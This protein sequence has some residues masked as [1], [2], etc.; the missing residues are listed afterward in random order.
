V[1]FIILLKTGNTNY[2]MGKL[3]TINYTVMFKHCCIT[4]LL[5]TGWYTGSFAQ[6]NITKNIQSFGAR[7]D[8][9][10]NDT[11]AF[12]KAAAFFNNRGGNGTLVIPKGVYIVGKQILNKGDKNKNTH[13]AVDILSF[14][15]IR[16]LLI[17]GEN[18]S[19]LR[20]TGNLKFGCFNP[21]TGEKFTGFNAGTTADY[22]AVIGN[23]ISLNNCKNVTVKNLVLDGNNRAIIFGGRYGDTG[24]QL[25]HSGVYI[26]NCSTISV[27]NINTSYFG[28]DG[29]M[30]SNKP[31]GIPDDIRLLKVVSEY[32]CRQGL[33]WVG[34]NALTAENCKFNHTGKGVYYSAPGAGTDIESEV[35]PISNG[36]FINCQFIDN[37]GCGMVSDGGSVISNCNFKNCI[38]WGTTNWSVWV[39]SPS[40]TFTGCKIYGSIVHG[41]NA[42]NAKDATKYINCFFEDKPYKNK[43][44][45]GKFIIECDGPRKMLFDSCTFTTHTTQIAWL[46]TDA[47]ITAA[48]K[49]TISNSHFIINKTVNGNAVFWL[50]NINFKNNTV[51]FEEPAAKEKGFWANPCCISKQD[52]EATKIIYK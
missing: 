7:G 27:E 28:L 2:K 25:S 48:E 52:R 12:L 32:N 42:V 21:L 15:D 41:F 38:F 31:S 18:G 6:I 45:F 26:F 8:G 13:E 20:Y 51:Q 19:V 50:H 22:V 1:F 43:P 11:E 14:K 24:I 4:I 17:K 9:K 30:I 44:P 10:T 46:N 39:S 36:S 37:Y 47:A 16:N 23:C 33:S 29:I 3:Y 35:G 34:G 5:I 49:A 40:F